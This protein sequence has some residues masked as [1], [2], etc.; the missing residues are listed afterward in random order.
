MTVY[1]AVSISGMILDVLGAVLLASSFVLKR[2]VDV[3][4][5][6][7]S[8]GSWDFH[9]GRGARDLLLSWLVQAIEA[10]T[11]AAIVALGFLCQAIAQFTP[12]API[13]YIWLM[14]VL[15]SISALVGFFA[16]QRRFV[17]R[18][19][20]QAVAFYDALEAEAASE[21]WKREIP[22]RREEV[23]VIERNPQQWLKP[24]TGHEPVD[25]TLTSE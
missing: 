3:F 22:L 10:R 18:A 25:K 21:D 12:S 5:D 23:R 24:R 16:L 8:L 7:R 9:I 4:H 11:G 2:P 20:R 15:V 17:S 14:P 1:A 6:V 19:A 13:A